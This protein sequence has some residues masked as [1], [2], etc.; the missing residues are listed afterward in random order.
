MEKV[1]D[2]TKLWRELA[3]AQSKRWHKKDDSDDHWRKKARGFDQLVKERWMAGTDSSREFVVAQLKAHPDST[4]LDIGAGTGAWTVLMA[5]HARHVTAVEP[6]GA[7]VEVMEEN[8]VAAGITNVEIVQQKWPEAEVEPHDFSL[9]SHAMYGCLDFPAF[10]GRMVEITRRMCLLV[11]RAP[12]NGSVMAEAAM[13]VWGQ[14][15]DSP[16]FQVAY[17]ALLQM[18]VFPNVLM[19]DTGLWDPWTNASFDAALAEVKQ[20]L[21]L[22]QDSEHDEFLVNLLRRR[23]THENDQCVWPRGVLSALV[24]WNVTN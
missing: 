16:N 12:I 14:P 8:L 24:Y 1:T 22:E 5:R 6:S 2:W 11:L 3:E 15:Y 13:R 21:C 4:V 9:C 20:R 17:N 19:E 7:M 18:D 10:V 23:L